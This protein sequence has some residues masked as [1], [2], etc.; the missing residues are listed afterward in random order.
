MVKPFKFTRNSGCLARDEFLVKGDHMLIYTFKF[1]RH[2]FQES[3]RMIKKA[4]PALLKFT[5]ST[6]RFWKSSRKCTRFF[7]VRGD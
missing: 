7:V 2:N 3:Y 4:S 6:A 1:F 5:K